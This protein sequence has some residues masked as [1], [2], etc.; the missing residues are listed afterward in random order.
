[1]KYRIYMWFLYNLLF[2]IGYLLLLPNFL[3]RMCKRG[4]YTKHFLQRFGVYA[5]E[6]ARRIGEKRRIL[7]HAVSVGE[8]YIALK[9]IEEMKAVDAGASF[10]LT[11]TTSTGYKVAESRLNA[12][13][14]LLY[15][16]SDFPNVVRRVMDTL[17]P[18]ALILAE[19][20][21]WPNVIRQAKIRGIPVILI[22]GRISGS[23]FKGYM[24]ARFFVS[25][26]L[27]LMDLFLVQSE[28]DRKRLAE[29][30]ADES[31]IKVLGTVK[32]D[33]AQ[34]DPTGEEKA[35]KLLTSAGIAVN[36][37]IIMGG[38]TWPGE[39]TALLDVFKKLKGSYGSLKLV[40]VPRHAERGSEVADDVRRAGLS[41]VRRTELGREA[42]PAGTHPD[43][44]L[45]DT[46]GELKSFYACAS[47]I[48]VGKS[49]TRHGGQNIIEPALYAKPVVIGPNMENFAAVVEDFLAAK[50]M[51]Q[52]QDAKGLEESFRSLLSDTSVRD[53][54]GRRAYEVVRDRRG[55]ARKS[56]EMALKIIRREKVA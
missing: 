33:V 11:T 4:G 20:E 19:S 9:F 28:T 52:V 36:D 29:L 49:L 47:V 37:L 53:S 6:I 30:G 1:M 39:E 24:M 31:K 26:V 43:V 54:Y 7:V 18:L 46:T 40:L 48:F 44:I 13:D 12:A 34:S 17:N 42:L 5:P 10:I 14:V 51:I 32:Y 45:V 2:P 35:R 15:F 16:P 38:S 8:I 3:M 22:N 23:S 50:A 56:A 25:R 55:V 21:L 27:K 41:F